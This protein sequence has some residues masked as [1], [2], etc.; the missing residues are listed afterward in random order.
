MPPRERPDK[1][2]KDHAAERLRQELASRGLTPEEADV[3]PEGGDDGEADEDN[4][5]G[6]KP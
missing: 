5:T 6:G 2:G 4:D 1:G 3:P